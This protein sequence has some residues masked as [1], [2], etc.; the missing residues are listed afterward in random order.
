MTVEIRTPTN[1]LRPFIKSFMII[2]SD[3]GMVNRILPDT[4][5]IMAFRYKGKT[6]SEAEGRM[7]LPAS[8]VLG[9]TK[10]TRLVN[11]AKETAMLLVVFNEGGLPA[12]SGVPL[13]ELF[14]LHISLDDFIHR[15]KVDTVAGQLAEAQHHAQ[16][17]AIVEQFLLSELHKPR[18]DP[19][20]DCAVRKIKLTNG[21]IR[22]RDLAASLS[23]SQDAFE[24][25]FNRAIGASPKQFAKI[26][27]LRNVINTYPQ[28]RN[29]TDAALRAGYFD[30]SHFIKDFEAFTGKTPKDF[31][32]DPAFW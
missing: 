20:I 27:R 31:F 12:F 13:H 25:R 32:S 11:Y 16:Q 8:A 28:A 4:S 15:H 9:L 7:P 6:Y 22:I 21:D 2:E 23:I 29:L 19:L 10:S 17:I 1:V 5:I 26:V 14:G 18:T 30:Q 3:E 24:K